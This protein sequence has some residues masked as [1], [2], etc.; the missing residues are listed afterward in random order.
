MEMN[1]EA[2]ILQLQSQMEALQKKVQ[3][4]ENNRQDQLSMAIVS[5]LS[6]IHI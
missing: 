5:G 6:L 3:R 2:T 4:L 1:N